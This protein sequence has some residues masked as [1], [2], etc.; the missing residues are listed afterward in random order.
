LEFHFPSVSL[1]ILVCATLDIEAQ[2]RAE[3]RLAPA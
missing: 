2:V 3:W 1:L